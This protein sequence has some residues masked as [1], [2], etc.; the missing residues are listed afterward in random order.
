M[1]YN[2]PVKPLCGREWPL[3]EKVEG[4][5]KFSLLFNTTLHQ[6]TFISNNECFQRDHR[7][8]KY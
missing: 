1:F 6:Q 8:V 2:P 3:R 7:C 5:G 4:K